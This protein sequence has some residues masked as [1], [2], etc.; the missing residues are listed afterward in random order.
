[1]LEP[2]G[3][4]PTAASAKLGFGCSSLGGDL[5]YRASCALVETAFEAGFRH[6][7]VA[8]PYGHGLA[9]KVLG[10]VLRSVRGEICLV[11]KAG[12]AHPR[13]AGKLLAIKR[14]V[15]PLKALLPGLWARGATRARRASAPV[16]Q[17]SPAQLK[18]SLAES[19]KRLRTERV[20]WL[21]LHEARS[22]DVKDE[23]LRALEDAMA[24]GHAGG[25]G[26]GTS[27][28][29]AQG[30]LAA[31]P[32]I[33]GLVQV[34]HFWGAY[35]SWPSAASRLVSHRVI[36][37]GLEIVADAG[38]RARL[39]TDPTLAPL[40]AA[41]KSE[42][43]AADL[44]LAGALREGGLMRVLVSSSKAARIRHL[45]EVA[46][47]DAWDTPATLLNGALRAHRTAGVNP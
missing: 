35:T 19:L 17:F 6:F 39:T 5:G 12:I 23:T 22:D 27:V 14:A 21:L 43:D 29:D 45:M 41:L 25:I 4:K 33:F 2:G 13:S 26:L 18:A 7:D 10:D 9:E 15:K 20:D 28:D 40:R 47:S 30:I 38:F 46:A 16:G 3:V 37:E 8:P 1:M 34:N 36:R 31:W 44:L 32:N 42:S 11:T 24:A